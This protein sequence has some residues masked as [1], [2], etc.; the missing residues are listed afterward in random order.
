MLVTFGILRRLCIF[1]QL[2]TISKTLQIKKI[3]ILVIL[4]KNQI[5]RN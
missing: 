1:N 4:V 2:H 3:M 5:L